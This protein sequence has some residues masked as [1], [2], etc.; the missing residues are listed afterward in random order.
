M[1]LSLAAWLVAAK[2]ALD[3]EWVQT[4]ITVVLGYAALF[5]VSGIT[6]WIMGLIGFGAASLGN[7]L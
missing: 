6:G 3:L 2:E 7:A 5:L 1:I 4:I